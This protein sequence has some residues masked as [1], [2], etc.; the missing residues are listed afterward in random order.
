MNKFKNYLVTALVISLVVLIVING[1]RQ[2]Q[3]KIQKESKAE[4]KKLYNDS[5]STIKVFKDKKKHELEYEKLYKNSLITIKVLKN[6]K[7]L[8][9]NMKVCIMRNIKFLVL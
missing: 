2:K 7:I 9:L 6:K 3:I 4:Y 1:N 5:L 8:S